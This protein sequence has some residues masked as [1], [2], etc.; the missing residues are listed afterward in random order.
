MSKDKL[1]IN[2]SEEYAPTPE[3]HYYVD[4]MD[5]AYLDTYCGDDAWAIRFELTGSLDYDPDWT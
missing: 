1:C 2:D 3:D 4:D 5:L